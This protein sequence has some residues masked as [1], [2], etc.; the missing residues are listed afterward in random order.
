MLATL[1]AQQPVYKKSKHR[2]WVA[3]VM[4]CISLQLYISNS[5]ILESLKIRSLKPVVETLTG[6]GTLCQF[7]FNFVGY[8]HRIIDFKHC[9]CLH[10]RVGLS[11]LFT[12]MNLKHGAKSSNEIHIV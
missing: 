2:G 12:D 4:L 5:L 1:M 7:P 6:F 9:G 8:F 10:F 11:L 3:S